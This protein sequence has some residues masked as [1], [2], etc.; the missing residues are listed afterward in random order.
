M[1]V[2]MTFIGTAT[3]LLRLGP[4][5][6]LTDPN[7]LH[8][9]QRAYLGHGMWSKRLTDPAFAHRDMQPGSLRNVPFRADQRLL[10]QFLRLPELAGMKQLHRRLEDFELLRR[11]LRSGRGGR[12]LLSR[13]RRLGISGCLRFGHRGLC[14]PGLGSDRLFLLGHGEATMVLSHPCP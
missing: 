13:F 11:A 10:E 3:A 1:P 4:F 5:T 8:A 9:G 14:V 2:E 12:D 7:F 6:V